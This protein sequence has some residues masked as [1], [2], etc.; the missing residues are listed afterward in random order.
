MLSAI[1]AAPILLDFHMRKAMKTGVTRE[2]IV[3]ILL[4]VSVLQAFQLPQSPEI[5]P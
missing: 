5:G 2:E 3:E 4:Q 1:D